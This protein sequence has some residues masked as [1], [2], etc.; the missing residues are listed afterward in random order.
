MGKHG[1]GKEK[2]ACPEPSGK[3]RGWEPSQRA[4][5]LPQACGHLSAGTSQRQNEAGDFPSECKSLGCLRKGGAGRECVSLRF[6][7][8]AFNTYGI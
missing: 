2:A 5:C 8:T 7:S 3:V 4:L 6:W 1:P